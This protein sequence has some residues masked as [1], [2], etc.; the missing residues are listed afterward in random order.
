MGRAGLV[1]AAVFGLA[2]AAWA[3]VENTHHDMRIYNLFG[4]KGVCEYCHVPHRAQSGENLLGRAGAADALGPIGSFCYSCH[5]GTV[6]PTALVAAPDGSV[7][8]D[9][10]LGSHGYE[11]SRISLVTSGLETPGSVLASGLVKI[12]DP[13]RPPTQLDC[14][15]CHDPHS[16]QHPPFLKAP[17]DELCTRCHSG[18]DR[19]GKGRWTRVEDAGAAN[20]PHPVG[21]PVAE[22]PY[23]RVR[24]RPTERSFRA[25]AGVLDVPVASADD[26]RRPTVHWQTGGHLVGPGRS[27]S[28][29]TCHSAHMPVSRLLV[30]RGAENFEGTVCSG[31][32]GQ[33]GRPENPGTTPYFHPVLAGSGPPYVHDH[34]A[35]GV[36]PDN[37]N[38]PATGL[39]NLFVKMPAE[40]PLGGAA[41]LVCRTCHRAHQGVPGQRL[42][43]WSPS[44]TLVICNECH[45]SGAQT[46]PTNWHH[47]V[48][49]KDYTAPENGEFPKTI[50]WS[51]GPET[52]GD[53]ADGLQCVDCHT[54]LAKSAHNW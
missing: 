16:D 51:R 24:G 9:A 46:T 30:A 14:N 21:M 7:G 42:V 47:P 1:A 23:D 12:P 38:V 11:I 32:H 45:R 43:R 20:G 17:I 31:C 37:P 53:L 48:G 26:L 6:I 40:W 13:A 44:G 4:E 3:G 35:H 29:V 54:E 25:P 27:V 28:C 33:A 36:V 5:D 10:L 2:G 8:L 49:Q 52:P 39:L 18:A 50:A 22:S 34:A 41:E 15:A 19:L